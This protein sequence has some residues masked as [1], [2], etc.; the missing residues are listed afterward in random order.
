MRLFPIPLIA[1]LAII[2]PAFA[3]A[4]DSDADELSAIDAGATVLLRQS[5]VGSD[6]TEINVLPY[7]GFDNVYGFD[8]L[9]PNL[10][11]ELFDIGTGRGLGKWSLRAGPNASFD[12]GRDSDDSPTLTGLD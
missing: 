6:Q 2:T 12:F 1:S 7:L 11:Y 8:L 4:Q 9:G 10:R 5:Y 3:Q